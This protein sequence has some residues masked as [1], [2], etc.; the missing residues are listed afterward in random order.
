LADERQGFRR[1]LR[2]RFRSNGPP[3]VFVGTLVIFELD[4][5]HGTE[6]PPAFGIYDNI[7]DPLG[8]YYFPSQ[9]IEGRLAFVEC[10]GQAGRR[11]GDILF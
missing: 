9:A 3:P 10:L 5:A 6:W 8:R 2:L 7:L 1:G 11:I 4:L